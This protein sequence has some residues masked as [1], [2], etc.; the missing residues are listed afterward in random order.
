MVTGADLEVF[1]EHV[2]DIIMVWEHVASLS[3]EAHGFPPT[4]VG[5][6]LVW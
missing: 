4:D 3:G 6:G 1:Q 5:L 2:R